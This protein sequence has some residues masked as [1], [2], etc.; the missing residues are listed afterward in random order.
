[1][2][3]ILQCLLDQVLEN[4]EDNKQE[5]IQAAPAEDSKKAQDDASS[6][7]ARAKQ[8]HHPYENK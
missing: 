2:G 3:Y 1:M 7:I 5:E 8:Q 6:I 4:P